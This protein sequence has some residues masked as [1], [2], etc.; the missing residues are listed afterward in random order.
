MHELGGNGIATLS[1]VYVICRFYFG[2]CY[3]VCYLRI[4]GGGL[5]FSIG[6]RGLCAEGYYVPGYIV[7]I[8]FCIRS[9]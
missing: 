9:W 8:P 7:Y 3:G 1:K 5:F 6:Y 4:F 2:P